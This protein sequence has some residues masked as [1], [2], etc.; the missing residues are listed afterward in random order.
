MKIR[1]DRRLSTLGTGHHPR[2]RDENAFTLAVGLG[3]K[4]SDGTVRIQNTAFDQR[5]MASRSQGDLLIGCAGAGVS[6]WKPSPDAGASNSSC[7]F[8]DSLGDCPVR[9]CRWSPNRRAVAYGD[10]AGIIHI[11]SDG[12]KFPSTLSTFSGGISGVRFSRDGK[13]LFISSQ[14]S[15]HVINL[16]SHV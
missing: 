10:A 2:Q 6:V 16:K 4:Q 13:R 15:V 1:K 7:V 11:V 14:S 5:E 3:A 12:V 9:S 8:E